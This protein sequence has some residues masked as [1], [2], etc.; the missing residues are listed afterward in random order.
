MERASRA[1]ALVLLFSLLLLSSG[2]PKRRRCQ[3]SHSDS[4]LS[5]FLCFQKTAVTG[6]L[7]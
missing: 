1:G 5:N 3:Q 4:W 2:K 6:L 7:K